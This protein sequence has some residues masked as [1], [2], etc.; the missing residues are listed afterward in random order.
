MATA[1]TIE[2][3]LER[4]E[5]LLAALVEREEVKDWYEVTEFARKVEKADFTVREWCRLKRVNAEKR[6]SGRGPHAAWVISHE[7]LL[8]YQ[9]EG[10]LP[11]PVATVRA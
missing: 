5:Q 8:R 6:G 4:M 7:E 9:R 1:P 10:L 2:Q 11:L 3:R